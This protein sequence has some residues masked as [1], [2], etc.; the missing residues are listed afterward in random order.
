MGGTIK[1]NPDSTVLCRLESLDII[2][3]IAIIMAI[4]VHSTQRITN[5]P[6]AFDLFQFGQMGC[7]FFF[8]VSGY[9]AP[10]SYLIIPIFALNIIS[11]LMFK[12]VCL[13]MQEI[14]S[15]RRYEQNNMER[16]HIDER[17]NY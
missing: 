16:N 7:Q 2:K 17:F 5:L 6:V 4:L 15:K 9:L 11:A 3:G 12:C 8:G 14:I 10:H 1:H 13:R